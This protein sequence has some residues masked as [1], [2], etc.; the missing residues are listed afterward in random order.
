MPRAIAWRNWSTNLLP[1]YLSMYS[2][3]NG[4]YSMVCKSVSMTG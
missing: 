1:P 3:S 4:A 2:S